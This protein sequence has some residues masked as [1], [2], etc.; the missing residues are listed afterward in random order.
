MHSSQVTRTYAWITLALAVGHT[1]CGGVVTRAMTDAGASGDGAGSAPDAGEIDLGLQDER[2]DADV[3]VMNIDAAVTEAACDA[4][5]EPLL[6]ADLPLC[7]ARTRECVTLCATVECIRECLSN[8]R[9]AHVTRDGLTFDCSSCIERQ[10]NVC[11]DRTGCHAETAA[12]ACCR[13]AHCD[14]DGC[15]PGACARENDAFAACATTTAG[16]CLVQPV[17]EEFYGLCYGHEPTCGERGESCGAA[18]PCCAGSRCSAASGTCVS[19]TCRVATEVCLAHSECCDGALCVGGCCDHPLTPRSAR[20]GAH[21]WAHTQCESNT[22]G[23]E[24]V[25]VNAVRPA[26]ACA[27]ARAPCFFESDCCAGACLL[28]AA[29][30]GHCATVGRGPW[31]D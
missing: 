6:E 24:G 7:S 11:I 2:A 14:A 28:G 30:G 19:E 13:R 27:D 20:N 21:C 25:C 16:F 31:L 3:D 29:E 15:E 23:R 1:G 18:G 8:D 22:C 17:T 4:S 10:Q 12:L 26:A 5:P 9:S